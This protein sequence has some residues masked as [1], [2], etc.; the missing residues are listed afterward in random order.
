M[1]YRFAELRHRNNQ[2]IL[3]LT[4][5]EQEQIYFGT[6]TSVLNELSWAGWQIRYARESAKAYVVWLQQSAPEGED[7]ELPQGGL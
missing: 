3:F 7:N 5:T 6:I 2:G 1:R 4:H